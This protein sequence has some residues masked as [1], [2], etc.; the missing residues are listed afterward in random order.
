MND[1]YD[2]L[3]KKTHFKNQEKRFIIQP[4]EILFTGKVQVRTVIIMI[5]AHSVKSNDFNARFL[6]SII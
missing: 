1:N 5:V 6:S 3:Q 4:K 2:F